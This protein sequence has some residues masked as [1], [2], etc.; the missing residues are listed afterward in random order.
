[1]GDVESLQKL[2]THV[3]PPRVRLGAL[4]ILLALY[5][6]GDASGLGFG[7][8]VIGAEGI[9]YKSGTWGGNWKTKSLNFREAV[10]LV[11]RIKS[12]VGSGKV[13][14]LGA[15]LFT[16]YYK[17]YFTSRKILRI[18]LWLYQVIRDGSLILHVTHMARTRMNIWGIDGLSRGNLLEYSSIFQTP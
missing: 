18:I 5:L 14:E 12:L 9:L 6:P 3:A 10:N 8:A 16:T 15:F 11:T 2:T 1:M 17:G 13:Q 4:D 7:S